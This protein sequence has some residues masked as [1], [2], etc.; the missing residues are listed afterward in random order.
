MAVAKGHKTARMQ[1]QCGKVVVKLFRVSKFRKL[2]S[3]FSRKM[4]PS[5]VAQYYTSLIK[6]LYYRI[7][8]TIN[9]TL[10]P[11]FLSKIDR[12]PHKAVHLMD[13]VVIY[14]HQNIDFFGS[15][16]FIQ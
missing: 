5:Q 6:F 1:S 7:L 13:Q 14:C 2:S 15:M 9:R 11:L 10:N 3:K 12:A 4:I 8:R 16:S